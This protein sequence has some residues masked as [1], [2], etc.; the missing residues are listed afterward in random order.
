MNPPLRALSVFVPRQR[1]VRLMRFSINSL[2]TNY[3]GLP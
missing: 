3:G 2:L 1:Q